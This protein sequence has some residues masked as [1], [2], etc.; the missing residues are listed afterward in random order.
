MDTDIDRIYNQLQ[1]F[2][3][4]RGVAVIGASR[5]PEKVG[6]GVLKSLLEGGVF[7]R[8]G[9][10]G[11]GGGIYAVNPREKEILGIPCVRAVTEITEPVDL[12]V[13]AVPPP[14]V[15]KVMAECARKGVKAAIVLT[16]GFQETGN[17]GRKLQDDFLKIAREAG[18]R[19]IGPNCL[20][21]FYPSNR[22]NASFGPTLPPAGSVAFFS[23]SGALVDS[24]IDWALKEE[25]GFSS[26]V[27]YGNKADVDVPDLLAWACRDPHTRAIALYL[28]GVGDGRYFLEM[29]RRVSPAKPIIAMKAGRS[30]KG[31]KAVSS[32][33][34]SL[35]GSY[36][37]YQGIF[38]Q[39][40]VVAAD[41]LTELLAISRA[42]A[43]QPVLDGKRVAIVTNGGGCGVMCADYCHEAGLDVSDPPREMISRLDETGLMHPA[44]SRN[45]PFDLVGDAGPDRYHAV[46]D[47]IMRSDSYDGVIVIQTL[48][49]VTDN[50]GDARLVVDLQREYNKPVLAAFM[51]GMISQD[52]IRHLVQNGIPN[53]FDVKMAAWTMKAMYEYGRWRKISGEL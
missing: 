51:G 29:A 5:K 34:G 10:K 4:P 35:S 46:L 1:H 15:P 43:D 49:A 26:I 31:V 22:L 17:E 6:H 2:F 37:V 16:A 18:I 42:L 30:P 19:V 39:A 53:F 9:L 13:F 21:L 50:M 20:G 33:T 52:A 48:Q 3:A 23:Q 25:Y 28:E 45:N 36:R 47:E 41:N 14:A 44:W 27:S 40:G 7:H 11:F 38:R 32:H 12:A 24:I 8:E